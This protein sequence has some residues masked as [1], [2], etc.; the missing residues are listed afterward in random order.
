MNKNPLLRLLTVALIGCFLSIGC[1]KKADPT[2]TPTPDT[3][4]PVITLTGGGNPYTMI[5]G[6]YFYDPGYTATDNIDGTIT[7]KVTTTASSVNHD[8]VGTYTVNYSVT[9]A[10]GNVGT[11]SRTVIVINEASAIA[12]TYSVRDS[13]YTTH[14]ITNYNAR[15]TA[16]TTQN[17]KLN[18]N[19]F[20]NAGTI[21]NVTAQYDGGTSFFMI[22]GESLG[23][24]NIL[25]NG[26]YVY[27]PQ[28]HVTSAAA[29][30]NIIIDYW[31]HNGSNDWHYLATYTKP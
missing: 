25:D 29:P 22:G 4:K 11:A 19:N 24:S 10:A 21:I 1:K 23:G 3:T 15:M 17:Q 18:I 16:S 6:N 31:V 13:N 8:L 26:N 7:A 2:P 28:C 5:M 30:V 14:A 12:G 20:W 27:F 9:D